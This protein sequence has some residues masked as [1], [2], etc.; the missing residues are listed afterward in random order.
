MT[1]KLPK[2]VSEKSGAFFW[3]FNLIVFLIK[4]VVKYLVIHNLWINLF[5]ATI[6]THYG[7]SV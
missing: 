4:N 5:G 1:M 3:H 6:D 7:V 2:K